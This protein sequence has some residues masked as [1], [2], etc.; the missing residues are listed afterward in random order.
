MFSSPPKASII[1]TASSFN[2]SFVVTL[3]SALSSKTSSFSLPG[4]GTVN[5][6]HLKVLCNF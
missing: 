4:V 2:V 1:S 3:T 5:L 6:S